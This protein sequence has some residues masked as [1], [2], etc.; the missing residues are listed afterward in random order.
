[1][2]SPRE[3]AQAPRKKS[4]SLQ[5]KIVT[6]I[7]ALILMSF[8][9]VSSQSQSSPSGTQTGS[10]AGPDSRST[11]QSRG[12]QRAPTLST[13]SRD[14]ECQRRHAD[15]DRNRSAW[16]FF[17]GFAFYF[18]ANLFLT[19]LRFKNTT[20]RVIVSI[21]IAALLG[22]SLLAVQMQDA[23]KV[24]PNPPGFLGSLSAAIFVWTLAGGIS[25]WL[26]ICFLRYLVVSHQFR[27]KQSA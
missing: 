12:L 8:F 5:L 24:C 26:V 21:V 11:P 23:L 25:T 2:N 3:D 19:F 1:M 7:S 6:L 18:L 4:H 17:W 13:N 15:W 27:K 14:I 16:S 9:P 10:P 22:P 20:V